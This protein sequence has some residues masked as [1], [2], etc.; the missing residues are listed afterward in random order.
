MSQL[1]AQRQESLPRL[2]ISQLELEFS[3]VFY[4]IPQE[5][6]VSFT[7]IGKT[8]CVF[9][10][11]YDR[12]YTWLSF[13][14][15]QGSIRPGESVDIRVRVLFKEKEAQKANYCCKYRRANARFR[16]VDGMEESLDVNVDFV[17]SCFGCNFAELAK[18]LGPISQVQ[19][20]IKENS[21][22]IEAITQVPK[23]LFR[24][25]EFIRNSGIEGLFERSWDEEA[26][27]QIRLNLDCFEPFVESAE[28]NSM[29]LVL[30]EML[31]AM[32]SPLIS[33]VIFDEIIKETA[34]SSA[35]VLRQAISSK[36][37]GISMKSFEY[38]LDLFKWMVEMN[39]KLLDYVAEYFMYAIFHI[40]RITSN[41]MRTDSIRR[42]FFINMIVG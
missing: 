40:K 30:I 23:E 42:Q 39:S 35:Q 34:I 8:V 1:A 12:M 38:L 11:E 3:R 4:K 29:V 16:I 28:C 13:S 17:G 32:P 20:S 18:I 14:H 19:G 31:E 10:L 25:V 5:Q 6:H 22:R 15:Q 9:S 24:I 27:S 2:R 37:D 41:N 26:I 21:Q 7:N 33:S 36:V